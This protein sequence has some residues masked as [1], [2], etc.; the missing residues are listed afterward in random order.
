MLIEKI[1]NQIKLDDLID[2]I[3][4]KKKSKI[5]GFAK[6]RAGEE[7]FYYFICADKS[8]KKFVTKEEFKECYKEFEKGSLN[9]A[10]Y[11]RIFHKISKSKPCN[12]SIIL[13]VF[14]K[15]L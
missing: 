2:K 15:L 11:K 14:N 5:I 4:S 10:S 12:F 9:R 13:G 8:D 1:R 7:V 6:N 3:R